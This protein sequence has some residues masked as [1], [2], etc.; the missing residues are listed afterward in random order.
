M[1][2]ALREEHAVLLEDISE[3]KN[4]FCFLNGQV[5]PCW[6]GRQKSN[7][8]QVVSR[9]GMQQ[10]GRTFM[11]WGESWMSFSLKEY[12]RSLASVGVAVVG[13]KVWEPKRVLGKERSD[14]MDL[15]GRLNPHTCVVVALWALYD[16]SLSRIKSV[17]LQASGNS[18]ISGD[19]NV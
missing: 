6:R 13:I 1:K 14:L 16:S 3:N 4:L 15:F 7:D 11:K 5:I 12:F 9:R 19:G 18:L 10:V 8:D 2:W 17:L